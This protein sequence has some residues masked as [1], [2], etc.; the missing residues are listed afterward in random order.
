MVTAQTPPAPSVDRYGAPR[1]GR[2]R[3]VIAVSVVVAL[4]FLAWLAWTTWEHA[5]PSVDSELVS[6]DIVDE[7]T[8]TAVLQVEFSD[9]DIEA[10]CML[11][12]LAED[13]SSVGDL[14]FTPDPDEGDRFEVTIRTERRATSVE[15]VGCLAEGQSR[16]R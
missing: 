9:D 1:P 6:F 14:S 2:R 7:H 15:S 5:N 16:R 4:A 3:A 11:R 8:A 12:A 13:H 10:S